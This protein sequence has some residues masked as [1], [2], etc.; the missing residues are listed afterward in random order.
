MASNDA[1]MSN[2]D[3]AGMR[4]HVTLTIPQKLEIITKLK[5]EENLTRCGDTRYWTVN[6]L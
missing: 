4:K 1:K 3:A 2:K 6:Y 5:S